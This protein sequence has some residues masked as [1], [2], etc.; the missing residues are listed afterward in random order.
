M[1]KEIIKQLI[2]RGQQTLQNRTYIPREISLPFKEVLALEKVIAI[3]GPRRVGKTYY[4]RQIVDILQLSIQQMIFIDFSEIH[5]RDLRPEDFAQILSCYFELFRDQKP[6]ILLDEIQELVDFEPALKYLLNQ[7]IPVIIT[8]SNSKTLIPDISSILRGKVLPFHLM[9]LSFSEYLKFKDVDF[10]TTE[11]YTEKGHGQFYRELN[12][13]LNWGGF[14]E[15]VLSKNF[16]LKQHLIMSYIDT[17]LFRDVVERHNISNILALNELFYRMINSFTKEFSINKCYNT[18]RSQGIKV[19]KDTLHQYAA[20]LEETLFIYQVEN[21]YSPRL[22]PKKVYLVDN[23]LYHY[24]KGT[25]EDRGKL[26]ENRVFLDYYAKNPRLQFI[27]D[28]KSEVD[29]LVADTKEL[30]QV[31]LSLQEGNFQRELA[32]LLKQHRFQPSKRTL[33]T[34]EAG[35]EAGITLP[36]EITHYSYID[37]FLDSIARNHHT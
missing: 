18:M 9:P 16:D 22:Q 31:S 7:K 11:L 10:T 14:P 33:I 15:V 21:S 17:M 5:S 2:L 27:K 28:Q 12:Q 26:F 23:G 1:N 4:L 32:S 3:V 24:L 20:Y 34:Y 19:G 37:I 35:F 36:D 25:V 29:L 6:F 13:F 8:G 30:V